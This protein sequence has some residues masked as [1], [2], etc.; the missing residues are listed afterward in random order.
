MSRAILL[1]VLLVPVAFAMSA[2]GGKASAELDESTNAT[3]AIKTVLKTQVAAWNSG[4]VAGFMEGYVKSEQLRFA[5]GD[6]VTTGWQKT[7]DRYSKRYTSRE[8]MGTLE[9]RD[10]EIMQLAPEYA[11]VFGSWHLSREKSVGDASGLFTLLM[12][13]T[14]QGWRVFHDH[15]SSAARE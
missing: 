2:D 7:L 3:K 4:D 6:S 15:T 14:E 8:I 10:L 1:L 12:K 9:F 11:E 13:K 5:S